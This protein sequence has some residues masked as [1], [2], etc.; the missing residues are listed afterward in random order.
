MKTSNPLVSVLMPA[1]NAERYIG[2]AI[3][4]ILNQTFDDFELVVVNDCSTDNTPKII[5]DFAEND[6]RIRVLHNE[7]NL[8]LSRSLNRGI[9]VARGKY[10]ARMDADDISLPGR[11]ES[12]VK[13][14]EENPEVGVS[15]GT[16]IIINETNAVIGKR[17]YWTGDEEIRKRIFRFS[18]FCH[19]AI[20]IRKSVLKKSG[21]Y[22]HYYNPAEDYDLY[23]R[24]GQCAK[25]GNLR[26]PLIKYRV[27]S[28]SMTTGDLKKM[29]LKTIEI[30]KKFYES[31]HASLGDKV[32]NFLH[33][34]SVV[35]PLIPAKQKI[36]L[37]SKVRELL[38]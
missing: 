3:E 10:I 17:R 13:Y 33:Y 4:S 5:E 37:F 36:W 29:E 21:L 19:P 34:G 28:G 14:M 20:I 27:V 18:P 35:F 24:I 26:E 22:N 9:Q 23:F 31:Y 12:Q 15:G 25:F 38:R 16:M 2:E 11:L 6:G 8:K 1:Y 7:K 32:Y 30:R